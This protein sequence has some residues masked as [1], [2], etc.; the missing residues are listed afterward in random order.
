MGLICMMIIKGTAI[1]NLGHPEVCVS[2]RELI[3]HTFVDDAL[4]GKGRTRADNTDG[5]GPTARRSVF[6]WQLA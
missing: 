2:R 4:M 5:D 1:G 3:S 6:Q